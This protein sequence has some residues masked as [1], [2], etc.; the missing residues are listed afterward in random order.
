MII[1]EN[2][3]SSIFKAFVNENFCPEESQ[4]IF[5]LLQVVYG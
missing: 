2:I 1:D 5:F 4:L 3:V